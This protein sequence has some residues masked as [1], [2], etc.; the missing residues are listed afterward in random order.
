MA[1][2]PWGASL[3][4]FVSIQAERENM[5]NKHIVVVILEAK[6]GSEK[7]LKEELMK[8]KKLSEQEETC[9]EYHV[10]EDINNP[11]Q[12]VLYENWTSQE[13]HAKQFQKSYI[14]ELG[15]KL[16]GILAQPYIAVMAKEM[17]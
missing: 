10:H 4:S 15:Q 9:I 1:F 7:L 6:P 11:A 16:E 12:V 17:S 13:D 14:V 8:V 3:T 5:Q 2:K